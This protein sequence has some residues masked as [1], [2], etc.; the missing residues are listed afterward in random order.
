M[1]LSLF[2]FH[3][4][5]SAEKEISGVL[6]KFLLQAKTACDA[7]IL[8]SFKA[9]SDSRQRSVIVYYASLGETALV[10]KLLA[11]PISVDCFSRGLTPLNAAAISGKVDTV[12]ML[13]KNGASVDL[14]DEELDTPLKNAAREGHLAIVNALIEHGADVNANGKAFT[15]PYTTASFYGHKRVMQAL[16]AAGAH[17]YHQLRMFA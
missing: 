9:L 16:E 13:L 11:T 8:T 3:S 4:P 5:S 7:E 14:R 2:L 12:K 17:T 1:L 15:T 6:G 10:R